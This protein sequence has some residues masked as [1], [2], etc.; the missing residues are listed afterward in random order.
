M[1][2]TTITLPPEVAEQLHTIREEAEAALAP[3]LG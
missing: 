3:D 1:S 2:T